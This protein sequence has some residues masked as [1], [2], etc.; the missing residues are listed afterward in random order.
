LAITE[1]VSKEQRAGRMIP[2]LFTATIFTS[3]L[4]L[5]FVQPLFTRMVLPQIGGAAAVWTTAML[6]FQTV[7]IGGYLYAH[8]MTRHVP[9]MA[10]IGIH[11]GLLL[12]ALLF[13][14]LAVPEGW[15]YDPTHPVVTQTLWLYALGVGLPF[16][17]L[18]ANAPLI[19]SWY[20]RSGGPSADDPYFLYAASNLGS[21]VALL[22]FPLIAE[23]IWGVTA[24]SGAWSIGFIALG[25]LLLVSGLAA[26]RPA[27]PAAA[28]AATGAPSEK[29]RPATLCYWAFLAFIPSSLMLCVTSKISTDLGSFPLV[30]VVPLALYL[31]TFVL[32]FSTRSPLTAD[33]LYRVLP[34]ALAVL[35]YLSLTRLNLLFGFGLLVV[36]FFTVSLLA[37]RL[38]FDARPD[39][40]HLTVF[41]L[42]MSVGGALG[43]LFNSIVAP[44]A[45]NRLLEYPVTVALI[46]L[47]LI[48]KR[49]SNP[50]RD[51]ALGLAIAVI[52]LMPLVLDI[53]ALHQLGLWQKT[54]IVAG[55]LMLIYAVFPA[56]PLMSASATATAVMIWSLV[57]TPN[58]LFVDRSFFG[59]HMVT[60]D[61]KLRRYSN[62]TTLHG[63]QLVSE[64]GDRPTP[65]TYYHPKGPMAQV[66]NMERS[67]PVKTVGIV[68]LGTGALSCHSQA[69]QD[70]HFYEIDQAVVDIAL[71]PK[72]FSFMTECA[73]DAKI[74]LGDARIVLQG[75]EGLK[76]DTLV[77]DAYSSDAIPVHL[78]TV[79]AIQLYLDRL[80]EDGVLVF[81]IS[82]RF[83][84]LAQPLSVAAKA[85]GLES[86][87]RYQ[88]FAEV[89][90]IIGATPSA[91]VVL[92]RSEEALGIVGTDPLWQALPEPTIELWTDDHA[93][94]LAALR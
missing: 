79:E 12:L 72:L 73:P 59:L 19:Q 1:A 44:L 66:V 41:Y 25:P 37:H 26:L 67:T 51:I 39:A 80:S 24:I 63:A 53:P 43:G 40:R 50:P 38:L 16:A 94:L 14:P 48:R 68:G 76:F 8:L 91:V 33:R 11:I 52:V 88:K 10:Q 83:Y 70:W 57:G 3:A 18:S 30:W 47:L 21:L 17:V 49:P 56:R 27:N 2:I 55:L 90:D 45:F 85:L 77:I 82:N 6:F 13:L 5:F 87:T 29:L 78:A 93:D 65:L 7:L 9:V 35:V 15:Q 86:R 22:A 75:Q 28:M 4:L 36:A 20:R 74:H 32:V 92:A 60:A 64:T 81:H 62:G 71:N 61:D 69:G 42:T 31:L 46:A 58:V 84:D 34:I 54:I 23:P 89:K